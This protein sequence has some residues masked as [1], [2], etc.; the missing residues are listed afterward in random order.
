MIS[1][2]C[3][4]PT[5][6]GNVVGHRP[7]YVVAL[8]DLREKLGE[9]LVCL[10]REGLSVLLSLLGAVEEKGGGRVSLFDEKGAPPR[11]LTSSEFPEYGSAR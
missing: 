2:R 10:G 3:R 7:E 9:R 5:K 1:R 11:R 4:G 8:V 6:G